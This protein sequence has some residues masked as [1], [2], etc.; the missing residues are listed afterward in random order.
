MKKAGLGLRFSIFSL[1]FFAAVVA[2]PNAALQ[3]KYSG[4]SGE[5]NNPYMIGTAAD[6]QVLAAD[7]N[8]YDKHFILTADINLASYSFSAAI[9]ACDTDKSN[10]TFEGAVF[11]GVFDGDGYIISNLTI[12]AGGTGNDFLG[13]FGKIGSGSEIKNLSLE[14][15]HITE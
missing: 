8:D 1:L 7:T 5:P 15:V 6:L 4:G 2:W 13:L 9:I 12:D 14:N 11:T 3:A 10:L